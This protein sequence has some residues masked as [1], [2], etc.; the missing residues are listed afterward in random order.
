MMDSYAGGWLLG[1]AVGAS[2]T[3]ALADDQRY[4]LEQEEEAQFERQRLHKFLVEIG[5]KEQER[6]ISHQKRVEDVIRDIL[7]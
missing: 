3:Y 1:A 4:A 5:Q 6:Y 7:D 2:I